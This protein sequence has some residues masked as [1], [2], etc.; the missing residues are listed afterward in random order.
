M[1]NVEIIHDLLKGYGQLLK[2][3]ETHWKEQGYKGA[4]DA[5]MELPVLTR[6]ALKAAPEGDALEAGDAWEKAVTYEKWDDGWVRHRSGL[7]WKIA[8]NTGTSVSEAELGPPLWGEWARNAESAHLKPDTNA[9][10]RFR[11]WTYAERELKKGG[12]LAD[13]EI[14]ALR[15]K[16]EI[17]AE[18]IKDEAC[19]WHFENKKLVYHVFWGGTGDDP[20]G[21][22]RLCYR[23]V[24]FADREGPESS[25]GP[26][27]QKSEESAR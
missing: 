3:E 26:G 8:G 23:F 18:P 21:I 17:L 9:P 7:W 14:P 6:A 20:Y 27:A 4:K 1:S 12:A 22:R 10:G 24:K 5:G 15:Q 13:G 19:K 11:F 2:L 16:M 25:S